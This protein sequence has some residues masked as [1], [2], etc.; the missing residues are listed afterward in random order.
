MEC[1]IAWREDERRHSSKKLVDSLLEASNQSEA[2]KWCNVLKYV[3]DLVLFLRNVV[4]H[5]VDHHI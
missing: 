2:V 4:W 3:I 1:Y 5:L